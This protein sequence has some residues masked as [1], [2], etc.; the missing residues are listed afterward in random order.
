MDSSKGGKESQVR[1]QLMAL[2]KALEALSSEITALE[3]RLHPIIMR[4]V[5]EPGAEGM[6]PKEDLVPLAAEI[7]GHV[8]RVRDLDCRVSELT[9]RLEL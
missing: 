5:S 9:K 7:R 3:D 8:G 6:V 4:E 1:K 2:E